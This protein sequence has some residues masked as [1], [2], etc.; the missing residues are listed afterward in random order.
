M[1]A[2]KPEIKELLIKRGDWPDYVLKRDEYRMLGNDPVESRDKAYADFLKPEEIPKRNRK[3][4]SKT[5]VVERGGTTQVR[6][7][8]VSKIELVHIDRFKGRTAGEREIV[9]WVMRHM[10]IEGVEPESCPDPIA[11]N[12]LQQCRSSPVFANDFMKTVYPKTFPKTDRAEVNEEHKRDGNVTIG[13]LEKLRKIRDRVNKGVA[14]HNRDN[15][16]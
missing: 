12:I 4:K 8:K 5:K 9:R 15:N 11:W 16:A 1:A 6:H 13:H 7:P 3:S 14:S 2:V 10:H